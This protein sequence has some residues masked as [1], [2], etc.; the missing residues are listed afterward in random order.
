M[1][2]VYGLIHRR[3]SLQAPAMSAPSQCSVEVIGID[4]ILPSEISLCILRRLRGAELA[5]A[6]AASSVWARLVRSERLWRKACEHRWPCA[7]AGPLGRL[8]RAAGMP[9]P[10]TM[11]P[12]V[13]IPSIQPEQMHPSYVSS[14]HTPFLP[15]PPSSSSSEAAWRTFY[16]EHDAHEIYSLSHDASACRP[17]QQRAEQR[18]LDLALMALDGWLPSPLSAFTVEHRPAAAL[19]RRRGASLGVRYLQ[20][21][22]K[23]VGIPASE[24][25]SLDRESLAILDLVCQSRP[26]VS[27]MRECTPAAAAC[28]PLRSL[29]VSHPTMPA[30]SFFMP[31]LL[32]TLRQASAQ[33]RVLDLSHSPVRASGAALIGLELRPRRALPCVESLGLA[34]CELGDAGVSYLVEALHGYAPLRTLDVAQNKIGPLGGEKLGSLLVPLEGPFEGP[35]SNDAAAQDAVMG[36]DVDEDEEDEEDGEDGENGGENDEKT[37]AGV[38]GVSSAGV[39]DEETPAGGV[40]AAVSASAPSAASLAGDGVSAAVS[41]MQS[42]DVMEALTAALMPPLMPMTAPTLPAEAMEVDSS[43]A[44]AFLATPADQWPIPTE[45]PTEIPTESSYRP[46]PTPAPTPRLRVPRRRG[47]GT[48]LAVLEVSFNPLGEEGLTPLAEGALV[49]NTLRC[50]GCRYIN[51]DPHAA[52]GRLEAFPLTPLL[53][54]GSLRSL[55]LS[56]NFIAA[57]LSSSV[58]DL[59][60]AIAGNMSLRSLSLRRCC[61]GGWRRAR[62]I[63]RGLGRNASLTSVDLGYNGLGAAAQPAQPAESAQHFEAVAASWLG[64]GAATWVGRVPAPGT[65][66]RPPLPRLSL[67]VDALCEALRENRTLRFLG[68]AHNLLGD[69]GALAIVGTALVSPSLTAIDLR[70]NGISRAALTKITQALAPSRV[71]WQPAAPLH[72]PPAGAPPH[73]AWMCPFPE[74]IVDAHDRAG[75]APTHA[76]PSALTSDLEDATV[77]SGAS[78]IEERRRSLVFVDLRNNALTEMLRAAVDTADDANGLLPCP[79]ESGGTGGGGSSSSSGGSGGSSSSGDGGA[80]AGATSSVPRPGAPVP[81]PSSGPELATVPSASATALASQPLASKMTPRPAP[82]PSVTWSAREIHVAVHVDDG[83]DE[84]DETAER[85][86]V[87][88]GGGA[89]DLGLPDVGANAIAMDVSLGPFHASPQ[90]DARFRREFWA[91]GNEGPPALSAITS[92]LAALPASSHTLWPLE[93]GLGRRQHARRAC[94]HYMGRQEELNPGMRHILVDWLYELYDEL[95]LSTEVLLQGTYHVDRFLSTQHVPRDALQLVGAVSLMLA[96]NHFCKLP[97]QDGDPP[98]REHSLNHAD[99]VV[100]WTDGTYTVEQVVEMEARVLFGFEVGEWESPLH[101]LTLACASAT[102]PDVTVSLA[103]ELL[104]VCAKEY[105]LLR[106]HPRLIAACALYLAVKNTR[107]STMAVKSTMLAGAPPT[108]EIA[109]T[110]ELAS[111]CGY[112]TAVIK[113]HISRE[114]CMLDGKELRCRSCASGRTVRDRPIHI[115][116][117][118]HG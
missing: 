86:S 105:T 79:P 6:C 82:L 5:V 77:G 113:E 91:S 44:G 46:A 25:E 68:L 23:S 29:G 26:R 100:Y 108:Q 40:S 53:A 89:A 1:F 2:T 56:Y 37:P 10:I 62:A 50:L 111:R 51:R 98:M 21:G 99:D 34:S 45:M 28:C 90:P 67:A 43:M 93:A 14:P 33:L 73:P 30:S 22:I 101:F 19:V 115:L 58:D 83:D 97:H 16:L 109:W 117:F 88:R 76:A 20:L 27:A 114:F 55:D 74:N 8:T 32:R 84:T 64:G 112:P 18:A 94:P 12:W 4:Q 39:N 65:A 41:T 63:A 70:S 95:E 66:G 59:R 118:T 80:G 103:V 52:D 71:L 48:R 60:E 42:A 87:A 35:S 3:V 102:L 78:S 15:S 24:R 107:T 92:A 7:F 69:L 72:P 116:L 54:A 85:V 38:N 49:S 75:S 13:C 104:V 47:V 17:E 110:S 81:G 9:A 61:I 96:S 57:S 106:V 36:D 11:P 31:T